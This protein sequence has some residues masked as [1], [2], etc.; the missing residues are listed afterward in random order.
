MQIEEG[1]SSSSSPPLGSPRVCL[2][3]AD[4][5]ASPQ[6]TTLAFSRLLCRLKV[7][8]SH[9]PP[10]PIAPK[11]RFLSVC[12]LKRKL[13]PPEFTNALLRSEQGNRKLLGL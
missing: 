7:C 6:G 11:L 2:Q 13:Q 10:L 1:A 5:T 4:C 12:L 8:D 9:Q 3:T